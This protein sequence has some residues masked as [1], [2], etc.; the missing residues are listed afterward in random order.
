MDVRDY[1]RMC[2]TVNRCDRILRPGFF[3]EN[4]GGTIGSIAVG[5]LKKGLKPT[6]TNQLVVRVR[7]RSSVHH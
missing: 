5:V 6:T 1:S 3:M 7:R 2:D 4:Y